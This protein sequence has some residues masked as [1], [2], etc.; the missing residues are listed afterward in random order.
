MVME[1]LKHSVPASIRNTTNVQLPNNQAC[2]QDRVR[3]PPSNV[4]LLNPKSGLLKPHS[5]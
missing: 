5:T 4:D 1:I 2:S 3:D